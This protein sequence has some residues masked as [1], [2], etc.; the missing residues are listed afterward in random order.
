MAPPSPVP[1]RVQGHRDYVI[2]TLLH[3]M[4]GPLDGKTYPAGV[5]VPMG[6]N[7]DEWIA[8]I[9]SYVR[10]SFGNRGLVHHAGRG[11]ARPRGDRRRAKRCGRRKNW[12][13]SV[14]QLLLAQPA[15]KLT[16]SHNS[17]GGCW[18][19]D[20]HDL[21]QPRAAAARNVVPGRVARAGSTDGD[22]VRVSRARGQGWRGRTRQGSGSGHTGCRRAFISRRGGAFDPWQPGI[23]GP[24]RC[25]RA[26]RRPGHAA[27]RRL[28]ARLQSRSV[29]G[30]Q[31]V[32]AR[33]R[34]QGGG[35]STFITFE[36]VQAKFVRI[37]QTA[38]VEAAPN[39]SIQ[40][41]RLYQV[42]N[43]R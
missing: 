18:C 40:R 36:P 39:W 17:I 9:A 25:R 2:K 22:S 27:G 34:W 31:R 5:M 7:T 32:D 6:T 4:T 28:P 1:P 19:V 23:S 20:L 41:L 43:I 37:T 33:Q 15:W 26:T 35:T 11:R 10:N 13:S 12:K 29:D 24:D 14:P 21:E 8:A 3:G 38:T 42:G 30:R 16:A